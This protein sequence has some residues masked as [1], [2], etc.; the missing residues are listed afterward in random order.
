[1]PSSGP[2]LPEVASLEES[3]PDTTG[4]SPAGRNE[5]VMDLGLEAIKGSG[6]PEV[7]LA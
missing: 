6:C 1:M 4:L 2:W 7:E 3:R 5:E